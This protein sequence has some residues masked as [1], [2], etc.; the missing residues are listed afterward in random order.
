[1]YRFQTSSL[2]PD[3][4][5]SDFEQIAQL[6]SAPVSLSVRRKKQ[7]LL[8]GENLYP[9]KV[10]RAASAWHVVSRIVVIIRMCKIVQARKRGSSSPDSEQHETEDRNNTMGPWDQKNVDPQSI[11]DQVDKANVGT[12]QRF[13][14]ECGL[15]FVHNEESISSFKLRSNVFRSVT[16]NN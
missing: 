8:H 10:L 9:Y 15:Y 13:C 4:Q 14:Y 1:M 16:V 3:F 7:Y 2:D 6:L 12:S 5:L 11:K